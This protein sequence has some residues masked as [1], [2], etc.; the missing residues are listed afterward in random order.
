MRRDH[1]ANQNRHCSM[2]NSTTAAD[3]GHVIRGCQRTRSPHSQQSRWLLGH[4]LSHQHPPF[5]S[6]PAERQDWPT[7]IHLSLWCTFMGLMRLW[8]V[9]WSSARTKTLTLL[10]RCDPALRYAVLHQLSPSRD[11][12]VSLLPHQDRKPWP[13]QIWNVV[14]ISDSQVATAV[15]RRPPLIMVCSNHRGADT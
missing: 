1:R 10:G 11:G 12:R 5:H 13:G 7:I 6:Q 4:R 15:E 8:G 14:L 2:A 3:R 9:L